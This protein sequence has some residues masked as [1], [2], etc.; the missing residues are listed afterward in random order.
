M[1]EAQEVEPPVPVAEAH[2]PGLVGVQ[3]Q[4]EGSQGRPRQVP[5]LFGSFLGGAQHDEVVAVTD[6]DARSWSSRLPRLI[7]HVEGDVGEQR[8]DG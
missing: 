2:D 4:P 8:R 1:V 7:E 6:Q 3:A 5:S